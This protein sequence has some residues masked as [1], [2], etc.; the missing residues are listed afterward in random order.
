MSSS[1][2]VENLKREI[3]NFKSQIKV[4]KVGQVMEVFDGIAKVY[5][6][7]KSVV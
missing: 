2:I 3:E 5:G 4:E 7:R 1:H 6:D